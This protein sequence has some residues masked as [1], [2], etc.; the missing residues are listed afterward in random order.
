MQVH[1]LVRGSAGS[2][3]AEVPWALR[4]PPTIGTVTSSLVGIRIPIPWDA[5][6]FPNPLATRSAVLDT[7]DPAWAWSGPA[8]G[9]GVSTCDP[10]DGLAATGWDLDHVVVLVDDLDRAIAAMGEV[11][12]AP[13]LRM[14][15]KGRPAAFFRVGP[16]LEVVQSPVRQA[17]VYGVA[18]VT[19]EPLE[20]I[21][22]RWRSMGLEVGDPRPA[23]QP[24]RRIL[25]VGALEAGL[26]VMSPDTAVGSPGDGARRDQARR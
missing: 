18:L 21:A 25:T 13:R 4:R 16:A 2:V 5:F 26:A 14:E 6:G 9:L 22:L 19:D 17:A 12:A 20:V 11:G 10:A 24:G 7:G 3:P 15:V 23:I 1:S 8:P